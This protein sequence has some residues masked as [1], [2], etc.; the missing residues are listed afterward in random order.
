MDVID[1]GEAG[2]GGVVSGRDE[3]EEEVYKA[4]TVR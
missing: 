3:V 4:A 1:V 2:G